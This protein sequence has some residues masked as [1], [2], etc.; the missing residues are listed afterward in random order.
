MKTRHLSYYK[1]LGWGGYLVVGPID[2]KIL[3]KEAVIEKLERTT[4]EQARVIKG[5]EDKIKVL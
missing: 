5:L 2:K 1:S 4:F 3:G